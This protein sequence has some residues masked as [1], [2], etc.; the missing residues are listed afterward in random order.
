L[1]QLVARCLERSTKARLRDIAD[2]RPYLDEAAATAPAAGSGAHTPAEA[3][4]RA[5]VS[6]RALLTSSAAVGLIG[7]GIG[8]TFAGPRRDPVALPSYQ[9]LTFRRGMIRTARFGPDF[10]TVLYGALWDGDVC[11]V[12]TV[13]AEGPESS[14]IA[15]PPATPLAISSTGEM[16][17]ALGTHLRGIMTYG[18]LARV[19]MAGGAPR[20]LQERVKYADWSPDGRDLAIVRSTGDRDVLEFPA[21]KAIAEAATAGAGFSFPRVSPRGDAVAVFELEIAGA[22][23]GK[24]AIIDRS[25]ARRALSARYVNVF[26]LAWHGDEVWFTAADEL[27]LLRNAVYAMNASGA[28]RIVARVPGNASLH[29][30]APDGRVL[31]ARTDDRGGISVRV[32]GEAV[33]RELSWLDAPNLVDM[34]SDGR[35]VLFYELGVGGGPQGS[36]YLRGTDGSPAVRL[37]DGQALAL[38]PDGRWAVVQTASTHLDLIPTGAG[39]SRRLEPPGLTLLGAR[40][41]PDGQRVLVR[42][43]TGQGPARMYVLDVEGNAV[44]PVTPEGLA[45]PSGWARSPDGTMVAVS[46]PNGPELFA[47]AGGPGRQVPGA[48]GRWRVVGW[49]ESGLLIS[50]DPLGGGAVSRVDPATGRR[51][52]WANIQPQDPAG[53]MSLNL[54]TLVT[55]PDGRGYGYTWHRA[56][57]DLFLVRGWR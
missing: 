33:E 17:L 39:S 5:G 31:I 21:G 50:D 55:T 7:A 38:S 25:G 46:T 49:I 3:I 43:R 11:R 52:S 48:S 24:V 15:L 14:S 36:V 18:T 10:Q 1:R 45:V 13:R 16:A 44:S 40:W 19:P 41:L 23:W 32:P 30:I 26:G 57:S 12:Y 6:R 53:I 8:A 51:E 4:P 34:S 9:R 29:D 2:A 35:R 22:L 54:A 28:V 37:G 56:T 27:P 47:I 42:A 20:E